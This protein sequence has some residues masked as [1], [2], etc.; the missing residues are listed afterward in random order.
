MPGANCAIYGCGTS[1]KHT[2]VGIFQIPK[3]DDELST[4]TREEWLK[5]ILRDRE[6]DKN[7]KQQIANRSLYVCEKHFEENL[8]ESC[9]YISIILYLRST[10]KAATQIIQNINVGRSVNTMDNHNGPLVQLSLI[11]VYFG[12]SKINVK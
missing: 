11:L 10:N 4:K 2:G 5:V 9:K 6:A 1:R 12:S 7:L 8:I 3:G